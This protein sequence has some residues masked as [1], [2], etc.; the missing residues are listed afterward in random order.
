MTI[1]NF[2]GSRDLSRASLSFRHALR[3]GVRCRCFQCRCTD[4]PTVGRF[5]RREASETFLDK[6]ALDVKTRPP[7]VWWPFFANMPKLADAEAGHA[8]S[9]QMGVRRSTTTIN[10]DRIW[11]WARLHQR[12]LTLA[13]QHTLGTHR[14]SRCWW[15]VLLLLGVSVARAAILHRSSCP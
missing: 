2:K 6:M 14:R 9:A 8:Q 10:R 3:C 15:G 1:L 11:C 12:L 4:E 13:V 5:G 7:E